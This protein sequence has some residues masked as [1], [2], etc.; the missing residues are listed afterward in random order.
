MNLLHGGPQTLGMYNSECLQSQPTVRGRKSPRD[1]EQVVHLVIDDDNRWVRQKEVVPRGLRNLRSSVCGP[2][3]RVEE[4]KSQHSGPVNINKLR[5]TSVSICL[6]RSWY[7]V[8]TILL[9][10]YFTNRVTD[11]VFFTSYLQSVRLR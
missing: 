6:L 10:G 4:A 2:K 9:V 7:S 11:H 8:P 1:V 5:G 3:L